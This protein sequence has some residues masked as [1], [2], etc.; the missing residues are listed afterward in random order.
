MRVRRD[1]KQHILQVGEG[2]DVDEFAAL[3]ERIKEGGAASAFEA[4]CEEP[5]AA[6]HRDDA[7]LIL[8]AVVI[9]G[10]AAIVDKALQGHPKR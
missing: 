6:A 10:Q 7:Q 1:S 8:G 3:D 4:A 5:V 2:R 9:D